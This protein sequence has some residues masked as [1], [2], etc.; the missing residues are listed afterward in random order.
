MLKI[1]RAIV[2]VNSKKDDAKSTVFFYEN[3][4][5]IQLRLKL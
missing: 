1:A 3:F 4:Y 5:I 2:K